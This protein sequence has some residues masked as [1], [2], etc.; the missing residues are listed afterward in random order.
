ML[1]YMAI[2][3][4]ATALMTVKFSL[5]FHTGSFGR[6]TCSCIGQCALGKVT[7]ILKETTFVLLHLGFG[8]AIR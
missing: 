6:R 5:A 1:V 8:E 7:L 3:G 2:G 4:Y